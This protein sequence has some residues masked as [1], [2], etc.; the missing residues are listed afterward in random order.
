MSKRFVRFSISGGAGGTGTRRLCQERPAHFRAQVQYNV[1]NLVKEDYAMRARN[2][3]I[4]LGILSAVV[5]VFLTMQLTSGVSADPQ[6]AR[7]LIVDN[8]N[9][10]VYHAYYGQL[11][12]HTDT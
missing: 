5:V 10:A 4:A 1:K 6:L 12:S 9:G 7:G 2:K 3:F 11:H 8:L